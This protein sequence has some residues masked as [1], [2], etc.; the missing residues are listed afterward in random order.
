MDSKRLNILEAAIKLFSKKGYFLTSMQEIAT[1]CNISK[2]SLYNHFSSKEDLLIQVF[3]YN[4]DK[5]VRSAKYIDIDISLTPKEKLTQMIVIEFEGIFQNKEYFRLLSSSLQTDKNREFN[6]LMKNVR[7]ELID[8]HHDILIQVYGEKVN[9]YIWDLIFTLQGILKEYVHFNMYNNKQITSK[10]VAAYI[11]HCLDAIVQ[12]HDKPAPVLTDDM[13]DEFKDLFNEQKPVS[14][15]EQTLKLLKTIKIK[16]LDCLINEE[17]KQDL[18][19]T[20]EML[21][22]EIQENEPRRF[23]IQALLTILDA[24][25]GFDE[26]I[27]AIRKLLYKKVQIKNIR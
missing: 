1:E 9:P 22:Q 5:M 15:E 27:S 6:A 12:N 3:K 18:H 2:G 23:L 17:M 4:H 16:M 24:G 13:M 8:W 26:E 11:V 25:L 10:Q 14:V 7:A 20:I 21:A 19:S